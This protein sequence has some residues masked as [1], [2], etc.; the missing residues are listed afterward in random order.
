MFDTSNH[1]TLLGF[2]GHQIPE[3]LVESVTHLMSSGWL[4]LC[5]GFFAGGSRISFLSPGMHLS[6]NTSF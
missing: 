1:L 4:V 3:Y 5:L 2:G 6:L